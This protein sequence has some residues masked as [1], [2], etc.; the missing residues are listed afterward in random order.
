MSNIF[1]RVNNKAINEQLYCKFSFDEQL[2]LEDKGLFIRIY[3]TCVITSSGNY[4]AHA[5]SKHGIT[6]QKEQDAEISH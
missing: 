1:L 5:L 4:L 2:L 3:A 6:F